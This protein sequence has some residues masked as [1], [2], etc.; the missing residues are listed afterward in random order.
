[1]LPEIDQFLACSTPAAWVQ[2]AL[3]RQDVMLLDHKA[4]ELLSALQQRTGV[5]L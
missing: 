5:S 2:A 4:C 1:M 3:Q